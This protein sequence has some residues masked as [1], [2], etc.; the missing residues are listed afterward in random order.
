VKKRL[1][2]QT[3]AG[4]EHAPNERGDRYHRVQDALLSGEGRRILL[5]DIIT[6]CVP[7]GTVAANRTTS[8]LAIMQRGSVPRVG[9]VAPGSSAPPQDDAAPG[10]SSPT[11][12]RK[13]TLRQRKVQP[14]LP[15]PA[16]RVGP[17]P[18]S[19]RVR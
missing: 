2:I 5:G 11:E 18:G 19:S 14:P 17:R 15:Q 10:P 3:F 8:L 7:L 6:H 13:A 1:H 4:V 12:G 16:S 9:D